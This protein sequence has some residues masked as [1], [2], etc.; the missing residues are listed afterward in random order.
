MVALLALLT[1]VLRVRAKLYLDEL[2]R[3]AMGR[4][5]ESAWQES[6]GSSLYAGELSLESWTDEDSLPGSFFYLQVRSKSG[7][8][9]EPERRTFD[10]EC[11]L[12]RSATRFRDVDT[13]EILPN[14]RD[15]AAGL[16]EE[17]PLAFLYRGYDGVVTARVLASPAIPEGCQWRFAVRTT[18][19]L[20]GLQ[21]V[22][23][24]AELLEAATLLALAMPIGGFLLVRRLRKKTS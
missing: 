4:Q 24:Y 5:L 8:A 10:V 19:S 16:V 3:L 2:H 7:L 15:S 18:P 13:V 9:L 17:Y 23:T 11:D 21:A 6:S 14:R 20:G 1:V 12:S 22:R